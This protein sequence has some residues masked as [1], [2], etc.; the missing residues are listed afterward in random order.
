MFGSRLELVTPEKLLSI[1][2]V[3]VNLSS[4]ECNI[5]AKIATNTVI[6]TSL[7]DIQYLICVFWSWKMLPGCF[8]YVY[9]L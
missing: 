7:S 5:Q 2:A 8:V 4:Q 9:L 3:D 6:E 1:T